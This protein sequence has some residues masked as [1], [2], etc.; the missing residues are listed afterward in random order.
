MLGVTKVTLRYYDKVGILKTKRSENGYR[1]YDDLDI[2]ILQNAIVLR[3]AN[4]SLADIKI[5]TNLYYFEDGKDCNDLAKDVVSRNLQSIHSQI[6]FLKQVAEILENLYPLF[7]THDL[8]KIN[9]N[10]LEATIHALF[11]KAKENLGEGNV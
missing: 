8:Y 10:E 6:S 3:S 4:F 2:H 9:Q 5:L 7:Q 11:L 1:I